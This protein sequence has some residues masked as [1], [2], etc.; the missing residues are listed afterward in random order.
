[1]K[2]SEAAEEYRNQYFEIVAETDLKFSETALQRD[3]VESR[4][5]KPPKIELKKFPVY[6]RKISS[7]ILSNLW[8]LDRQRVLESV[9]S[10]VP[11]V[12][13]S[14]PMTAVNYPKTVELLKV[15]FGRE[16]LFVQIYVRELLAIVMR[17][18]TCVLSSRNY[19]YRMERSRA[20]SDEKDG[21][22]SLQNL[23]GFL[24]KE[25]LGE[26]MV[27]F[28]R[29]GFGVNYKK[30]N[31]DLDTIG[32]I[33]SAAALV[34]TNGCTVQ[35]VMLMTLRVIIKSS[36]RRM[37]GRAL[38][39]T[40]S[41]LSCLSTRVIKELALKPKRRQR[42]TSNQTSRIRPVFDASAK[43]GNEPSLND[44]LIKGLNLIE[45]IPDI[46][47]RFRLHK[48]GLSADIEKAFLQLSVAPEHRDFLRFIHP[49]ETDELVVY[50]HCRVVFGVTSTP[51]LLVVSLHYLFESAPKEYSASVFKLRHSFYVDNCVSGVPCVEEMESFITQSQKLMAS[52]CFNLR[53][54]ESNIF[55]PFLSNSV[56][57]TYLL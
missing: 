19:S 22:R 48:I 28:A 45:L 56:G 50:R 44:N 4:K 38:V 42:L 10:L 32:D 40:W 3:C 9:P 16:D 49:S 21:K 26:E 1:M 14:L 5:L 34:M 27:V 29:T 41:Q 57:D 6:Q 39:D 36:N 33:P 2:D 7:S 20:K 53:G 52:A 47:D 30:R 17:N 43:E 11:R 51:F 18:A 54:W 31:L 24:K 23:M 35:T 15:R 25:V 55:S 37:H 12:V 13:E 46:I 8:F